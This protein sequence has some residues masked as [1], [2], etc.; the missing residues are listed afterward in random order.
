M[1]GTHI[2]A[3][4]RQRS[5]PVSVRRRR[6]LCGRSVRLGLRPSIARFV[7]CAC[8]APAIAPALFACVGAPQAHPMRSIGSPEPE[9]YQRAHHRV[10]V[11]RTS[12]RERRRGR[13][14]APPDRHAVLGPAVAVDRAVALPATHLALVASS[15]CAGQRSGT[16]PADRGRRKRL[17][18]SA[19][20][21]CARSARAWGCDAWVLDA[22][23]RH[24][25]RQ[26][27]CCWSGTVST[28]APEANVF[29]V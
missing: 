21:C 17:R 10:R 22:V 19:L 5:S 18:R 6:T 11:P 7:G 12:D 29:S 25:A 1:G 15:Q 2:P 16:E 27:P 28:A 24:A 9:A 13:P 8:R 14:K 3:W 23:W 26:Q 4:L 20:T